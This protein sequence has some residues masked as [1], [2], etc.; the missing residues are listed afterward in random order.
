VLAILVGYF[1]FP[2][3][4]HAPAASVAVA[5]GFCVLIVT[6]LFTFVLTRQS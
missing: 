5:T 3:T 4:F 1:V 2:G 6:L